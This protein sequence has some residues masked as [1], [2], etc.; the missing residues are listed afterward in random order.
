MSRR[1]AIPKRSR[2]IVSRLRNR[3]TITIIAGTAA[4][5]VL[6]LVLVFVVFASSDDNGV[7]VS[8]L[9]LVDGE[10]I[11]RA[12][13]SDMQRIV[14]HWDGEWME[15]EQVLDELITQRLLFREAES[16]GYV[17]SDAYVETELITRLVV[18][19]IPIREL[20]SML[21]ETGISYEEF[22]ESRKLQLSITALLDDDI[23]IPE[24]TEEEAIAYYE[25]YRKRFREL[26][27]GRE[28]RPFE[29]MRP[30]IVRMAGEE[31]REDAILAYVKELRDNADI[32][33]M[34]SA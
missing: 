6:A 9:A 26:V 15:A 33:Y 23:E 31:K 21:E 1:A 28:P 34:N 12:D 27:P 14:L 25:E 16:R 8:V 4:V 3:K 7:P 32:V 29:D 30:E 24:I 5:V 2:G 13:V 11:T 10:P 20:Y 18:L 22:M 19:G 17:V